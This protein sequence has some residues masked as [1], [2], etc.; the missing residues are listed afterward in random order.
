M[1]RLNNVSIAFGSTSAPLVVLDRISLT[2]KPSQVVSV[3]GP[4]GCGKS[5]MLNIVAGLLRP[6]S[7]T[8]DIAEGARVGY[9]MQETLLLGW[10]TLIENARLGLEL[11]VAKHLHRQDELLSFFHRFGLSGFEA[12]LPAT[13]SGGMKQRVAL[14]RTLITDP[15]CLLL[16]EPFS[17]LDFEVKLTV[18]RALLDVVKARSASVILVTHDLDDAIALSDEIVVLTQR[19]ATKRATIVTEWGLEER[20]PVRARSSP[21]FSELFAKLSE[22]MAGEHVA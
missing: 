11:K 10:R 4:S 14:I 20:D 9:M 22:A 18:Q 5:T 13:T 3:V 6:T 15:N 7:G 21:R 12:A 16:D 1:I 19:P 17:S 8:I 2:C